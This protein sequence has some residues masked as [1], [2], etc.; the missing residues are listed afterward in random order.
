M[1]DLAITRGLPASGK[2]TWALEWIAA[3]GENELRGRCNRDELRFALYG[4]YWGL[5]HNQEGNLTRIQQR[6]VTDHLKSGVS[7][8][9]D[10]THLRLAHAKEW[11]KLARQFGVNFQ[12]VDFDVPVAICVARDHDREVAG[13]RHV[14]AEVIL[15]MAERFGI[16]ARHWLPDVVLEEDAEV[17]PLEYV[18]DPQL[19]PAW[20]VDVDGT[21]AHMTDRGPFDWDKVGSDTVNSVVADVVYALEIEHDIVVMSGRDAVCRPQTERWLDDHGIPWDAL[22][23][24]EQG[25]N[26]KDA[27]VKE[28]IFW[29]DVAPQWAVQGVLDDRDQ[30]VEMWRRLGLV[31]LQVAPGAF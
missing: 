4:K 23:M 10:D 22:L 31:C 11:A 26:R 16:G 15:G 21:L 1:T 30:V 28:E 8:V 25:D 6:L 5:T 3:A 20:L 9:V 27:I 19:P 24:R 17:P 12:V 14:G 18:P 2:T 29:R 7:V 13:Q